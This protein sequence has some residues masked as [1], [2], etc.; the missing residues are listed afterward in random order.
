MRD[1]MEARRALRAN[2]CMEC[3]RRPSGSDLLGPEAA[4]SCEAACG[5]FSHLPRLVAMVRRFGG[6]PPC[7]YQA[8]IQSLLCTGCARDDRR[9]CGCDQLPLA[10]FA[11]EVLT[12]LESL[13]NNGPPKG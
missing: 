7:G 4:R 8:A 10:R 13:N 5:V 1:L 12:T 6:E 2:V 9:E 11:G 3:H